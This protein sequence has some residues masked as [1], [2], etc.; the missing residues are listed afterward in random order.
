MSA[1]NRNM[2]RDI[3]KV[4]S[5]RQPADWTGWVNLVLSLDKQ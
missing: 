2:L 5:E 4:P 1:D 3:L